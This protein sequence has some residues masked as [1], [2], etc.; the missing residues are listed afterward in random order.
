VQDLPH[1]SPLSKCKF[2]GYQ[3]DQRS[4][5]LGRVHV[6]SVL[7]KIRY[8]TVDTATSLKRVAFQK[9]PTHTHILASLNVRMC[10]YGSMNLNSFLSQ[11]VLY[12]C[13]VRAIYCREGISTVCV[14]TSRRHTVVLSRVGTAGVFYKNV[15]AHSCALYKAPTF[16]FRT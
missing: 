9:C 10:V 4:A 6:S 11:F 1:I 12:L 2:R 3:N 15:Y 16:V 13:C 14:T 8:R 5:L 7:D